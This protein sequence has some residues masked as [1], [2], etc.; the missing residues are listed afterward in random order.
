MLPR[1]PDIFRM[2]DD[3]IVRSNEII[4]LQETLEVEDKEPQR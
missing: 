4:Q 1:A 2:E 3:E